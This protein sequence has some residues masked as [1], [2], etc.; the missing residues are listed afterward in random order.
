MYSTEWSSSPINQGCLH[1]QYTVQYTVW[2]ALE[3]LPS[4]IE[5]SCTVHEPR[6]FEKRS[7]QSE[8]FHVPYTL[9]EALGS[10]NK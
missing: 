2:S 7:L 1:V 6:T 3:A 9:P 10:G 4:T 8:V 5:I